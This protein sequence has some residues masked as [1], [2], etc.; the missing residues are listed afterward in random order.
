MSRVRHG[1]KRGDSGG[2]SSAFPISF[3]MLGLQPNDDPFGR[4]F[5]WLTGPLP[6]FDQAY[7]GLVNAP[8][9]AWARAVG[10][11][12]RAAGHS[13]A[14]ASATED[15]LLARWARDEF[16]ALCRQAGEEGAAV[17]RLVTRFGDRSRGLVEEVVTFLGR[18]P[19]LAGWGLPERVAAALAVI[20][21][22]GPRGG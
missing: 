12:L 18:H 16:P 11:T 8:P 7:E 4:G 20:E 19:D 5:D 22:H 13:D 17:L 6:P 21:H 2:D 10:P 3:D 1:E 15:H 14:L 9:T